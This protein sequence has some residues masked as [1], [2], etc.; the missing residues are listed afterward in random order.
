MFHVEHSGLRPGHPPRPPAPCRHRGAP[1]PERRCVLPGASR[2]RPPTETGGHPHP[3]HPLPVPRAGAGAGP[4]AGR[5]RPCRRPHRAGAGSG[6]RPGRTPAPDPGRHRRRTPAPAPAGRGGWPE[7]MGKDWVPQP[8]PRR[9]GACLLRPSAALP[10]PS[11]PCCPVLVRLRANGGGRGLW[12]AGDG[13]CRPAGVRCLR[14]RPVRCVRCSLWGPVMGVACD[15]VRVC[16]GWRGCAGV[17]PRAELRAGALSL[18]CGAM[19]GG[20]CR[21]NTYYK[22]GLRLACLHA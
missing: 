18:R 20:A 22:R 5:G 7:D 17:R 19:I 3:G 11:L 15:G 21:A 2:E 8:L 9:A 12:G 13:A 14:G 6:H 16:R 4:P 10:S 1:A